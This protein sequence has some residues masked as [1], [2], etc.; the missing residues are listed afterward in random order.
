MST[1]PVVSPTTT[2]P[3]PSH[4]TPASRPFRRLSPLAALALVST[5]VLAV[6]VVPASPAAAGTDD[7]VITGRGWGHGRGLGQ[8]GAYGYAQ[9]HG[10]SSAQILDH[11]YGGTEAGLVPADAPV[12]PDLVRVDL[13]HIRSLPT[14]VSLAQGAIVLADAA[15]TGQGQVTDGA[16]RLRWNGS[17][18]DVDTG[19][20]CLGP[21][22]AHSSIAGDFVRLTAS[23]TATGIDSLLAV[24]GPYYRAWYE[25]ELRAANYEGSP[26]TVNVVT[27][28]QYLRGVIPNE[29]PASWPAAALEAQ[30]VAARSYALAG[31]HRQQ[32]YADTCDS[33]RCQVYDG[34]YTE[35]KGFRSSTH[36]RTD[37][38]VAATAGLVRITADGEV[39][40]TEFSS[41]TGGWTA[42]GD[43]PAVEDLGDAIAAN[44]NHTW[45]VTVP[46][47]RLEKHYGLGS[48]HSAQVTERLGVGPKEGRVATVELV[49][50]RGQVTATGNGI[51][52]LLGL[53]SDWFSFGA[54]SG[55]ERR[56]THDGAYVDRMFQ[57]LAGRPATNGELVDWVPQVPDPAQRQVLARRLAASGHFAG[58]LIDDLYQRALGRKADDE[59]RAYWVAEV[60]DG[61]KIRAV[62]VLFYGS[63]EYYEQSGGTDETFIRALYRDILNRTPDTSG[64]TYW[65]EQMAG[66]GAGLDD[67]A[68]GF[69]DSVESR[70]VRAVSLHDLLVG[71]SPAPRVGAELA[72][73]LLVIDDVD[74]AAEIAAS[75]AAYDR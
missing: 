64:Q 9:D 23:S 60:G 38:A 3:A 72:D 45:R 39:A 50:A 61:L 53:K 10:W 58:V 32:P 6:I 40:R 35:R 4:P 55:A 14:T 66:R 33:I 52:S 8:Y 12:N 56:D 7:L 47:S 68:A 16:V 21:W 11:Y 71:S 75:A 22:T 54:G 1:R 20:T 57:T 28:E 13:R 48:F 5:L 19:P 59:G 24:C 36:P 67:V 42:G 34:T 46:V 65:L 44:P 74:L 17:G 27:I 73:R 62:G 49:F 26:R 29:M 31:D 25:G 69:Y 70:T 43:F 41:S 63:A 37:A 30:T 15:G 51:R 2:P 18:Y